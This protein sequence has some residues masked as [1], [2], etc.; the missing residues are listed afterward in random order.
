MS[1]PR[2]KDT[3]KNV[4]PASMPGKKVSESS[5]KKLWT[6]IVIAALV[7]IAIALI[8]GISYYRAYVAPFHRIIMTVDGTDVRI[9]YFLRRA[10]LSGGTGFS[11][12]DMLTNEMVIKEAAPQYGITVTPQDIDAALRSMVAAG[13]SDNETSA[14]MTDAE[15]R[16]WYRQQLNENDISDVD[17]REIMRASL[18]ASRLHQYLADRVPTVAEQ[19]H[20]N[21]IMVETLDEANALRER[22]TM[23]EDFASLA[24]EASID[25]QTGEVGGDAGW[26]PK[27]VMGVSL[28][29]TVFSLAVGEVSEPIPWNSDPE[30]TDPNIQTIYY[31]LYMVSEKDEAREVDSDYLNVLKSNA[32]DVW[33]GQEMKNHDIKYNYNSEINAWINWQLT[34]NAPQS[35]GQ[36][37]GG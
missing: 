20:L 24:R 3:E 8:G 6:G 5:R 16:E 22:W 9:D 11:T 13:S 33:L 10:R 30:N 2:K 15:F 19:V 32:L 28:D 37:S 29:N 21:V 36:S 31:V 14:N 35:S 27:G 17:Y 23:G 4:M 7:V 1:K 26:I 25:M 18:L 12:L 34:K